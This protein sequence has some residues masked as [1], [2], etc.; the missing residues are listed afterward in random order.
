M[1]ANQ[2]YLIIYV[3]QSMGL[4]ETK[5]KDAISMHDREKKY[6]ITTI[7]ELRKNIKVC[8]SKLIFAIS[9]FH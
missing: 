7:N 6:W 9:L 1:T 5:L 8:L 4:Q 3:V 2:C